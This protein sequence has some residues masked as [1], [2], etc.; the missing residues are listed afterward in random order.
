MVWQT[1]RCW[2]FRPV[3]ILIEKLNL[4]RMLC[5]VAKHRLAVEVTKQGQAAVAR[6]RARPLR[7]LIFYPTVNYVFAGLARK[8]YPR[9]GQK[10]LKPQQT[11][12]HHQK[13]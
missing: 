9:G 13:R 6:V 4:E 12:I 1:D 3:G 5:A 10:L 11:E 7:S 8:L 2:S